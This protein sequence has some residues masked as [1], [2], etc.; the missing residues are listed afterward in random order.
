VRLRGSLVQSDRPLSRAW[1]AG[2]E[3]KRSAY[4]IHGLARAR[5]G[6]SHR[7]PSRMLA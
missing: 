1:S 3:I 4:G 2:I 7:A 6:L 5:G